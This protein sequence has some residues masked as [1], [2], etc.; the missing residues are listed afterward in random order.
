MMLNEDRKD[1]QL[2]LNNKK[3][4]YYFSVEISLETREVILSTPCLLILLNVYILPL[5]FVFI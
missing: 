4:L 2:L 5:R 3:E 1:A